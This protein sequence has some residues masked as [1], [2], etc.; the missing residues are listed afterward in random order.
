MGR[1]HASAIARI[2]EKARVVA[3][4]DPAPDVHAAVRQVA[5]GAQ[6]FSGL[7]ELLAACDVDVVHICTAPHTHEAFAERVLR[8]KRHA[9]VEKPFAENAAAAQRL[10]DL[11]SANGVR[12]CSG[13]Q[14][15][16]EAP[17]REAIALLP[18]LGRLVH[19]ESYFS[20]RV[21]KRLPG[22]RAPLR[23]DHQLLDVLPH[24]TY[25]LLHFLEAAAP[26]APL[27]VRSIE[28][29]PGGT[30][31]VLIKRGNVTG[32]L[33]MTID[34]RPVESYLKLVGTYG[35]VNADYVR[36]TVQRQI[37]PGANGIDKAFNPYRIARQLTFGTTKALAT[38]VLKK[39][40]SYPGLAESFSAF[41]DS[42]RGT[43]NTV[44]T[45]QS[46]VDTVRV[47]EQIASVLDVDAPPATVQVR[48]GAPKIVLT[49][50]TG[51]LGRFIVKTL[52]EQGY[53]VKVLARRLPAV[54][55]R[56]PGAEYRAVDM[57]YGLDANELRGAETVI[58]A[59]AETAGGWDEHQRNS[60]DA[61]DRLIDAAAQAGV[62][63]IVHV[64]SISVMAMPVGGRAIDEASPLHENG[65][66]CGPYA[67]GKLESERRLAQR[68]NDAGI[69][70]RVVRPGAFVDYQ[71]FDPPGLLGKRVGNIFVA[72]GS[73]SEP[74]G[75]VDVAF[76]AR[77]TVWIARN[78]ERAPKVLHLFDP[79]LPTKRDLV[80]RLRAINPDLMVVWMPRFILHPL[81]WF[82][83]GL[84]KVLRPGKPAINVA[85]V[86]TRI[87]FDTTAVAN[88]APAIEQSADV[89]AAR[90]QPAVRDVA[91]LAA[92]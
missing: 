80:A 62:R 41:Y 64:S 92:V 40:K 20:F 85:K 10:I 21:A 65:R 48:P 31:H 55:D 17:S 15:L 13:H 73:R 8:A 81:S 82:A 78:F 70:V 49:G 39:Q 47:C 5:P 2:P 52:V 3:V 72:I 6:I 18:K 51:F 71:E 86:F 28:A 61:S 83:I 26:N 50:G 32:S 22:P 87:P 66:D 89:A 56:L 7:D 69:E 19:V 53:A 58:H 84:Q 74:L 24:P 91:P 36:S 29:G 4:A 23:D 76:A 63:R 90:S 33:V 35:T 60:L 57:A 45:P 77:A 34:G 75:V 42:I 79:Q 12:V 54:W 1:H 30:V 43:G 46:I 67:W 88:L 16:Y 68:A 59:A 27:E 9:Y 25:V 38:R 44:V 14:L 11:A 37:G